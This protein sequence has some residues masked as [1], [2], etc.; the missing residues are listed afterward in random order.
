MSVN[1][2]YSD[3]PFGMSAGIGNTGAAG[4]PGATEAADALPD[5]QMVR[6]TPLYGTSQGDPQMVGVGRDDTAQPGQSVSYGARPDPL[7]GIGAELGQ[8]GAGTPLGNWH[9]SNPNA[10]R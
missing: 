3:P 5:S 7:T 6:V 9:A 1:S 8:T 10:G 4:T 2:Q